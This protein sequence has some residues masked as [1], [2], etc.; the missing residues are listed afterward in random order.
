L[1]LAVRP[2]RLGPHQQLTEP[3]GS[4]ESP[5]EHFGLLLE[6]VERHRLRVDAW[7][8]CSQHGFRLVELVLNC[9]GASEK[10]RGLD[11]GTGTH[12]LSGEFGAEVGVAGEVRRSRGVHE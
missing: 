10:Q 2:P 3:L 5:V 8:G 11:S 12:R 6:V 9:V 1:P 4:F 7:L